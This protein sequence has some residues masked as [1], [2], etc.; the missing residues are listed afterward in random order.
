MRLVDEAVQV[1][2]E[3]EE[4]RKNQQL[5]LAKLDTIRLMYQTENM[6]K[7]KQLLAKLDAVRHDKDQQISIMRE[8]L[9]EKQERLASLTHQLEVLEQKGQ[10]AL[11]YTIIRNTMVLSVL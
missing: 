5:M 9:Q 6:M 3:I 1:D 10:S 7:E 4:S 11:W 2:C 8:E